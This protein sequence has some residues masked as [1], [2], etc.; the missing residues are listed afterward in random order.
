LV[1]TG[2][3]PKSVES[4]APLAQ[5]QELVLTASLPE[6]LALMQTQDYEGIYLSAHDPALWQQARI[7]MQNKAIV[8]VLGEGVP[9]CSP[10]R[11][12]LGK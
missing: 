1:L 6:A 5:G 11:D 12:P 10:T 4:L 3:D 2:K 7:L 9:S 8:E